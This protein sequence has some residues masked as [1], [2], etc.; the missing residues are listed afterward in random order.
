MRVTVEVGVISG[1][2]HNDDPF[3]IS[4]VVRGGWG[5]QDGHH[6]YVLREALLGTMDMSFVLGCPR[7]ARITR[8]ARTEENDRI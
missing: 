3:G 8:I 4:C 7:I 2:R 5:T 6:V 1:I